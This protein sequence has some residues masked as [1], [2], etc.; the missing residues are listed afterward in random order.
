MEIVGSQ[1]GWF[2]WSIVLG[3][4][5]ITTWLGGKLKERENSL[6]SFFKGNNDLPWW[7]VSLSLIATKTSASTFIAVPAFIF[8]VNG[9]LT[10]LQATLGFALGV[11]LMLFFFLKQYYA[12][13]VYSPY[14]FIQIKLGGNTAN[15]T[16]LIFAL[17]TL[18]SQAVKLLL[19]AV[20]LSVVSGLEILACVLII[21]FFA[22]VWSYLGGI[23]TVI[24]TDV[25]QYFIFTAGAIVALIFAIDAIPGGVPQILSIADQKS[26]LVL[27]ELTTDPRKM[28]LWAAVLGCTFFEF[29]SNA[30]DHTVT[31]RALCCRNYRE[32]RKALAF[33]SITVLTTWL[34]AGVALAL[35]AYYQLHPMSPSV[36]EAIVK[37]PDRLLPYFIIEQLPQGIAGIVV[38]AIFAAGISTLDSALTALSHT[39][40]L[41]LGKNYLGRL[42]NVSESKLVEYSRRGI[43]IWGVLIGLIALLAIPLQERG[44]LVLGFKASGIVYGSLMGIAILALMGRGH[45]AA[46]ALS[47]FVV[48]S[49]MGLLSAKEIHFFW[50]YPIGTCLTILLTL[51]LERVIPHRS[52]HHN[53]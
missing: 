13:N 49:L 29:C 11:F 44:L 19:T 45:F 16:R 41:G 22:C 51:I 38:A 48:S 3:Y 43:L 26:K 31:Q 9:N 52:L 2:S 7:A 47:A 12:E 23:K 10:Y 39:T 14:D 34:M 40:V 21:T 18:L 25:I 30:V 32:A 28:S 8:S 50:W 35:V 4:L 17:G 42:N 33:S 37:E 53:R 5:A 20:V 1:F 24:W 36:A 27:I 6:K 15:L 46:I